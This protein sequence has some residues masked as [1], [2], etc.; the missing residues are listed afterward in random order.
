MKNT[1]T[2]RSIITACISLPVVLYAL[3]SLV[4]YQQ[5][6]GSFAFVSVW[7]LFP[8]VALVYMSAMALMQGP[9]WAL[10]ALLCCILLESLSI[11]PFDA[12]SVALLWRWST[13]PTLWGP[14]IGYAL[15]CLIYGLCWLLCKRAKHTA[16]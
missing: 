12:Y 3:Y 2:K 13:A 6:A 11:T 8:V 9:V 7:F 16:A 10:P 5:G 1:I 14:V 15:G 4:G